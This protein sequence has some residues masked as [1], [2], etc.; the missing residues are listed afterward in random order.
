[1]IVNVDLTLGLRT[2]ILKYLKGLII[3]KCEHCFKSIL[4]MDANDD[5]LEHR[6]GK[7]G[8]TLAVA[9][10]DHSTTNKSSR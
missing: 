10:L 9:P 5:W 2:Q 3:S 4:Y 7:V 6:T 1:M 8:R